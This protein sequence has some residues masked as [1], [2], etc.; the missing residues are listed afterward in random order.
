MKNSKYTKTWLTWARMPFFTA[1][2]S[3]LFAFPSYA[4]S[5][6]DEVHRGV[7]DYLLSMLDIDD[8]VDTNIDVSVVKIDDRINIPECNTGFQFNA[9]Q[10]S[11][12]Q[13]YISVRVSC[14]NNDWYLFTSAQVNRTK[15]IVVTSGAVSPG[16]V[17][18]ATN[19][20][21]AEV[22]I[23]RLRHTAF[24]DIDTLIGARMKRRIV[25]GQAIQ[26]NMLCFV[27][28]G[29]RITI[30]ASL[31][32]MAVKTSGIAQQDGVVGDTIKV[33]NASSQKMIIA[34]VASAQEVVVHL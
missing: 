34:E 22:D 20:T 33:Q 2:L 25:D 5:M 31:S 4:E 28:K 10:E 21:F 13:S 26:S 32:G 15:K 24:T 3:A 27:C 7:H 19:L 14:D 8:D 11:L 16:T 1:T 17:L 29:D 18:T 9:S 6:H 30:T 23:R 12:R